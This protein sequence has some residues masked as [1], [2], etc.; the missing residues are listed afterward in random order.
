M[1]IRARPAARAGIGSVGKRAFG[2]RGKPEAS[3][4]ILPVSGGKKPF[5]PRSAR[6][7]GSVGTDGRRIPRSAGP[8]LPTLPDSRA[9][10]RPLY[11]HSP[12]RAQPG[13][14]T[15]SP[16]TPRLSPRR[17]PPACARAPQARRSRRSCC[18]RCR[19]DDRR[20]SGT[21]C[22]IAERRGRHRSKAGQ[23][24]R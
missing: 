7:T 14:R 5:L 19:L 16:A 1:T 3:V 2:L 21:F 17:A 13:S 20:N 23:A 6:E 18:S 15:Q 24:G 9:T 4:L 11:R 10:R 12:F 22:E 8:T